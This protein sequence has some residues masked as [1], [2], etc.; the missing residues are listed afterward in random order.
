MLAVVKQLSNVGRRVQE[1]APKTQSSEGTVALDAGTA[2]VLRAHRV[3]QLQEKLAWGESW[4]DTGRIFT[5]EDGTALT[6][7]W[8]SE[9]FERLTFAAGLPPIR[10]HDLRHV[11]ATLSLAA[12]NDMKIASAMLRHSSQSITPDLYTTVLPE[13]AHTAAE[14]SVALV[15]RAVA[16]GEASQTGGL[17][18]VSQLA[19]RRPTDSGDQGTSRSNAG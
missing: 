4:T 2:A 12:G 16:V 14:A 9:H 13:V 17:P 6:P 10:L 11:A 5:R 15:P 1:S 18:S 19:D 7:G 8:V 3:L